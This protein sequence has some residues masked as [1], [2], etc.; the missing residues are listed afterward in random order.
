MQ[1]KIKKLKP[2]EAAYIA[3][4]IDGEGSVTLLRIHSNEY[5]QLVISISN[6]DKKMLEWI[7]KKIGL[8][9][10]LPKKIYNKN[11]TPTFTYRI[12]ARE[13]LELL[14]QV[15]PYLLTYK[16]QRAQMAIKDLK[17]LTIRN[18]KYSQEM[19][20]EKREF[21]E[22][23]LSLNPTKRNQSLSFI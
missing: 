3:A 20:K 21:V 8:G 9:K 7:L 13:A 10:I 6:C 11:H 22:K 23:F 5:R 16:K 19:L 18:G 14:K 12:V 4:I 17:R 2:E 15:T 1:K